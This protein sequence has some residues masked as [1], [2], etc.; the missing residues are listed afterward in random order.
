MCG[1][2]GKV[3]FDQDGTVNPELVAAMLGTIRHRGPDG[4]GIHVSP[5]VGLGHRRLAIIDLDAG[6]QPLSNEDGT[7]WITFNG[8]IYNYQEL[9]ADLL[10]RGHQFRT[11]SD[12]EVIVHLYEDLG[13]NCVE[14][15]RGM[16]AFAIWDQKARS[17]FLARDRV[18]IKPLYYHL[19][20]RSLV[21]GSEIKAILADPEVSRAIAPEMIDRFLT[22]YYMP[23]EETLF[24]D[25]RKLDAG[26]CM[27]VQGGRIRIRRYWDLHFDPS[28]RSFRQASDELV[29]LLEESVDLHMISDVPVGFLLSGGVDS[30]AVLGF[31][32]A[33]AQR[34]LSSFTLGFKAHGITDERPY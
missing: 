29:S 10:S 6:A 7:V 22:F 33:K 16:F 8:E 24:R 32:A 4:E 20:N 17:L 11:N 31:A 12:T 18:G 27:T 30:T 19:D 5:Q 3:S 34:P 2:C 25:I 23:G 14:K 1:I 15:L 21:F 26:C 13:E 28:P 9:R